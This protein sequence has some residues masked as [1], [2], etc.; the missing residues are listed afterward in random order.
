VRGRQNLGKRLKIDPGAIRATSVEPTEWPGGSLGCPAPERTYTLAIVPG[1]RI[2]LEAQGQ[3]YVYH[4]D[5][6]NQF[7]Y[8]RDGRPVLGLVTTE[9]ELLAALRDRGYSVEAAGDVRQP[10][11]R[12]GGTV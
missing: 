9:D 8:C 7:V 3:Q 4:A 11:L 6:Q 12:V 2:T 5:R 1:Y 10:F